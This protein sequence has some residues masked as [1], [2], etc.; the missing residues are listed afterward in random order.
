[1]KRNRYYIQ[2]SFVLLTLLLV[3][4]TSL[5]VYTHAEDCDTSIE[6]CAICDVALENQQP[7]QLSDSVYEFRFVDIPIVTTVNY[8][9]R[10]L[11]ESPLSRFSLFGRPPPF[12][13]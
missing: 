2:I 10:S 8:G 13:G 9:Y 3:K 1:M 5:H 7:Y 4:V 12:L 6:Q 11:S